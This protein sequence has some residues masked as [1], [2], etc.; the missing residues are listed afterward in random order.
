[1]RI[2]GAD[3]NLFEFDYDTTWAA[4]FLSPNEQVYGRYGGRDSSSADARMSLAGLHYA[5]SA[6]LSDHRKAS[7]QESPPRNEKRMRVEDYPGAR[8]ARGCIHCHQ[9]AEIQRYQARSFGKWNR[10]DLWVYPLPENIGLTLEVDRGD[11]VKAVKSDSSAAHVGVQAGDILKKLNGYPVASFADAQFALHKAPTKGEIAIGWERADKRLEGKLALAVG[12]RQTNLTW[13]PSMLHLLPSL[14][15]YG[16]DLTVEEKK[17]LGLG[18]KR[19]A[20]RQDFTVHRDA[21]AI[22]VKPGD[23]IIGLDGRSM[24]MTVSEFLA[25]VRRNYLVGDKVTLDVLRDGKPINL[26]LTLR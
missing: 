14:S 13:R 5:M 3:L 1:M 23:I 16:D 10:E 9:V 22:G 24:E 6:A 18:A 20:F 7:E 19:L 17:A 8:R 21:Q 12:W 26:P 25:H 2:S 11:R 15:L 4:F